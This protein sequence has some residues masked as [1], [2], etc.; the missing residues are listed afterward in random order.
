MKLTRRH[1]AAAGAL[2]F[3][4][5]TLLRNTSSRA[6]AADE[7][8]VK[9]AVETLRKA[10]L[11]QDKAK[12]EQLFGDQLSYGHSDGRVEDK[13]TV[14]NGVMTRKAVVKSIDFPELKVAI[15]GKSIDLTTALR[16]ITPLMTV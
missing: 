1:L 16:V 5:S 10:G 15:V 8:A 14:I 2:A 13:A 3:G 7:T 11:T 12:L 9:D 4:A 6:E